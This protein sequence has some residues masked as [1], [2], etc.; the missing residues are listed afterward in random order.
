[1]ARKKSKTK[2][3]AGRT[4]SI[5]TRE[6][7]FKAPTQ[8]LKDVHFAHVTSVIIAEFSDTQAELSGCIGSKDKGATGARAIINLAHLI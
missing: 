5:N 4:D 3:I 1:M 6:K 2:F 7:R 8:E